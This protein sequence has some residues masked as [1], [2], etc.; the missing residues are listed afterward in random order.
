MWKPRTPEKTDKEEIIERRDVGIRDLIDELV[1]GT[2]QLK[3]L[4]KKEH[5]DRT[6]PA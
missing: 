5:D 6:K 2:Q 1:E 4:Y 3:S